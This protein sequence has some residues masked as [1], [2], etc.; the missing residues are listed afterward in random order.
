LFEPF[1]RRLKLPPD[2]QRAGLG[3]TGLGLTIVRM[4]A[5]TLKCD[6][7]FVAPPPGFATTFEISWQIQ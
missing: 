4:L 2:R 5:M 1:V 3:G 7:A 6:V